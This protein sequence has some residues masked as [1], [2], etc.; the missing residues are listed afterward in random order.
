MAVVA[1]VL[2]FPSFAAA[3]SF[4]CVKAQTRVE[5]MICAD[6]TLRE[7]DEYLG[8]YYAA[9]RD[10][11]KA[12]ASC[13]QTDQA[14]WLKTT[15]EACKDAACLKTAYLN[16]LAE[17][18]ALQP[19]ASAI[20]GIELPRVPT[21]VSVIA[22]AADKVAAPPNPKAKPFEATGTIL[23][24]VSGGD[25]FMLQTSDGKK[26]PLMLLMFMESPASEQLAALAKQQGTYRA[27]GHVA[28]DSSR[29]F[30]EPSR[31]TYI[32]RLPK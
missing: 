16:R 12:G 22:P 24:E 5:K 15:R 32:Y 6:Q 21:L 10:E 3:Q 26:L 7:Y 17:L 4:D 8:R 23:N 31:C 2:L 11:L 19:G 30:F 14:Q 28:Q 9:G 13:L 18:D 27:R 29:M 25:G 1:A 20:R